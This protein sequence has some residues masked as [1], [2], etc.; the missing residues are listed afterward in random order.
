[1]PGC[2]ETNW[3]RPISPIKPAWKLV[4]AFASSTFP[5]SVT[6]ILAR[7]KPPFIIRED[8]CALTLNKANNDGR[9]KRT[10][11]FIIVQVYF[12]VYKQTFCQ[13]KSLKIILQ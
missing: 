8:F 10:Y 9:I 5:P 6:D 13:N 1:N 4:S 11:F 3:Q 7:F 2:N 12:S